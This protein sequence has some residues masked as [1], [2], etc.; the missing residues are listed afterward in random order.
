M[1]EEL[2]QM[3]EAINATSNL[4]EDEMRNLIEKNKDNVDKNKLDE[5][6]KS[7]KNN[8]QSDAKLDENGL[9]VLTEDQKD[10]YIKALGMDI[11]KDALMDLARLFD[12]GD[13]YDEDIEELSDIRYITGKDII[14]HNKRTKRR[15]ILC[16]GL[17]KVFD[18]ETDEELKIR[19]D[20][21]FKDAEEKRILK[22]QI[23]KKPEVIKEEAA[24]EIEEVKEVKL[25]KNQKKK[26]KRKQLKEQEKKLNPY[27]KKKEFIEE[28]EEEEKKY[29]FGEALDSVKIAFGDQ[30]QIDDLMIQI[31]QLIYVG[32]KV[33]FDLART[34]K[35]RSIIELIIG[36]FED[37]LVEKYLKLT[38]DPKTSLMQIG[39]ARG[40][41]AVV[42]VYKGPFSE[43]AEAKKA[44]AEE[45]KA[46]KSQGKNKKKITNTTSK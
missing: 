5:I 7:L 41:Y 33:Y 38:V 6:I 28:E 26:L 30:K 16:I 37:H 19:Q 11:A 25:S 39:N 36:E 42:F 27:T 1:A 14:F 40:R 46:N 15:E 4:T 32:Q 12:K 34:F 3:Q 9:P 17:Q 23:K 8:I 22:N 35:A 31:E 18:F 43:K 20:K 45:N 2:Q 44:K 21:K 29:N 24:E 10:N 13:T